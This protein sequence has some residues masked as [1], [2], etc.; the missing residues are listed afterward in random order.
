MSY[1]L[2]GPLTS[3]NNIHYSQFYAAPMLSNPA[4]CGQLGDDFFRLNAHVRRQ[5]TGTTETG[6]YLYETSSG[7]IDLSLAD[8]RI[9]F[10]LYALQDKSGGGIYNTLNVYPTL[11][12]SFIMGDN[13]L[14]FGSQALISMSKFDQSLIHLIDPE[15]FEATSSYSDFNAGINYKHDLYFLVANIGVSASHLLQPVQRF[16]KS[17]PGERIPMYFRAYGYADWDLT[18][19]LR[20]IPGF[21]GSFQGNSTN[22]LFGSNLAYKAIEGAGD[23]SR[24]ILGLWGRTNN[25]N[26]ESII[27]KFGTKINKLQIIASYDFNLGLSKGGSS[28][29]FDG[30]VNTFE[31]SLIFTGKPKIVPPLLEDDFI[32]NP[33][34]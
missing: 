27:P 11:S 25:G 3:Q 13:A 8:K 6:D 23:G 12:Y 31:I 33:R 21:Y 7:G 28:N 29:Y 19:K 24:L 26:V 22:L 32:L 14:T 34:F 2:T 30:L 20:L 1:F 17:S 16:S 18:D 10:G 5:W 15:Q 9:G 4:L